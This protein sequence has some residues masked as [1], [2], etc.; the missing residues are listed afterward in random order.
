MSEPMTQVPAMVQASLCGYMLSPSYTGHSI[1]TH[2][3]GIGTDLIQYNSKLTELVANP[4][5]KSWMT[6]VT[7]RD[8]R[9]NLVEQLVG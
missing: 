1:H 8:Y 7:S 3:F 2:D 5:S 4:T 9:G 6:E